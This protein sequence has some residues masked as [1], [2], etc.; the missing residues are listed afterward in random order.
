MHLNQSNGYWYLRRST[1]D[2]K[3]TV[4][5]FGKRETPPRLY[6]PD[7]HNC[8]GEAL[9]EELPEDSVDAIVTDP[10]Y[11]VE[12]ST[13]WGDESA[14]SGRGTMVGDDSMG[15]LT[16]F[17]EAFRRVLKPDGHCFVFTRW[18]RFSQM[19]DQFTHQL[20]LNSTL[21]WDKEVYGVG[22][23]RTWSPGYEMIMHFTNGS[24]EL[25]GK[26]PRNVLYAKPPRY[27]EPNPTIHPTQKPRVL[28]EELIEKTTRPG[29]LV[30]DPFG[31]AYSTARA[32]MRTFR[33]SVACEVDPDVHEAAV[34]LVRK[35]LQNDPEFGAD[36]TE[37]SNL[38]I[39][40]TAVVDG[41]EQV[42]DETSTRSAIATDG[43]KPDDRSQ[44]KENSD[45]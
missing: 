20:E 44:N 26:R 9:L 28:L 43:G 11:G 8:R 33:R 16:N 4:E 40:P 22:D 1:G 36:W 32:A 23:T 2:G 14:M 10:P 17:A 34:S 3:E 30:V 41:G 27:T 5:S 19:R 31:G 37:I 6:L 18:D 38:E 12:I 13:E 25:Y 21:V 42:V 39:E 7:L 35:E 29:D 45:T 24:P 15:F